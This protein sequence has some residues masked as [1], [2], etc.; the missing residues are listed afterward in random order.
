MSNQAELIDVTK[1]NVAETGF[2]CYMS[3]RK[4]EGFRRKLGWVRA[5]LDEGM[6]IKMLKL[7]DR[8]FIESILREFISR[9]M[10]RRIDLPPSVTLFFGHDFHRSC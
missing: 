4:S 3:K 10:R 8:G 9:L 7:P 2:F 1:A 6:R 5:R